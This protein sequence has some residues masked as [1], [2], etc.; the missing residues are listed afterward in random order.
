M[1]R[2]KPKRTEAR[3]CAA[4]GDDTPGDYEIEP[5]EA[6]GD[7]FY[8]AVESATREFFGFA[9]SVKDQRRLVA[10]SLTSEAFDVFAMLRDDSDADFAHMRNIASLTALKARIRKPGYDV[11]CHKCIWADHFAIET[12]ATAYDL[13]FLIIDFSSGQPRFVRLG[14]GNTAV[15]LRRCELQHYDL[16]RID[17][18]R[19]SP[20]RQLYP[21]LL[22]HWSIPSNSQSPVRR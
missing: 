20:L 6:S 11:G 16:V 4:L 22:D 19:A 17:G 5:M 8:L 14:S 18:R 12:V 10:D 21:D 2:G 9:S 13:V 7:C 3:L 15:M 1:G